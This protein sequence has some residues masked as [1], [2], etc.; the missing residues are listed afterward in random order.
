VLILNENS[1]QAAQIDIYTLEEIAIIRLIGKIE[2]GDAE[3]FKKLVVDLRYEKKI[4]NMLMLASFGGD[5]I[6]AMRIGS[7]VRESFIPTHAPFALDSGFSCN[8]Y[9]L[10]LKDDDCNCASACFLI[11][12][13][14][15][16][17]MGNVLGLHRPRFLDEYL[18]GLSESES[19]KEYLLMY[20]RIRSYLKK[21]DVPEHIIN[22]MFNTESDMTT[23]LDLDTA[24]SM[25]STP[26]FDERVEANCLRPTPDEEMDYWKLLVKKWE[27]KST[28]TESEKFYFYYLEKKN[29]NYNRCLREK[30]R[31]EQFK[32]KTP[33]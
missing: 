33:S 13:A 16:Y 1:I 3:K 27:R 24:R 32:E 21:M 26:L 10:G 14:G 22:K 5:A 9:P 29:E 12:V 17:R 30:V 7:I 18:E 2:K 20:E 4:I 8:E 19:E 11:W 23:Y 25:K 28:L 6:E 31:E 15:V